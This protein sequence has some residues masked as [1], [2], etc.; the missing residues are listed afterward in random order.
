MNILPL[1]LCSLV[2]AAVLLRFLPLRSV[3]ARALLILLLVGLAWVPYPWGPIAW[4]HSYT[5]SFSMT[6]V[7]LACTALA[8]R[9]GWNLGP[10]RGELR[11]LCALIVVGAAVLYPLSLGLVPMSSYEWGFGSYVFSSV[12]LVLGLAFWLCRYWYGVAVLVLA[13][14]ALA[15]GVLASDNLW[16]YLLDVWLVL[17]ALGWLVKD[18]RALAR[19][20]QADGQASA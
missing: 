10:G 15:V 11:S 1:V 19:P 5:T 9:L 17:W 7:V 16:D 13:Q 2:Y 6:A 20:R 3:R 8:Q 18:G 14:F 4:M 12:L